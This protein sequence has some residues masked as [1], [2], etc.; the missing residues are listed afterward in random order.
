VA[1]NGLGVVGGIVAEVPLDPLLHTPL[2]ASSSGDSTVVAA[3][4]GHTI[5]VCSYVFVAAG[6]VSVKWRSST[7]DLSGAMPVIANGG[8]S[9]PVSSPGLGPLFKTA[10]GEALNIYLSSAV[11]VA[12]HIGYFLKKV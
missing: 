8:I 2:S 11:L 10:P 6:D 1:V 3:V 7:T 9:A 5:N 12:G 4:D